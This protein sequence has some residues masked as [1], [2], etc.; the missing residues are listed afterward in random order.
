[1]RVEEDDLY[2]AGATRV[3]LNSFL[4]S[5]LPGSLYDA[6]VDRGRLAAGAPSVSIGRVAPKTLALTIG[7]DAALDVAPE[8]LLAAIGAYVEQLPDAG[9]PTDMI[10]RLQTR[11]AEARA[12]ADKDPRQVYNRLVSWLAGR[13]GYENL[14]PWPQQIAAVSPERMAALVKAFAGPGRVVTGT[15]L[16]AGNP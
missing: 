7:A 14:A 2:A 15:L 1:V 10:T 4:S 9:V 13:S 12:N 11:F 16:P 5:R 8:K 6:I 3:L